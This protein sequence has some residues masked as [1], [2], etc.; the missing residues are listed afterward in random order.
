MLSAT[1]AIKV[2][3]DNLPNGV[4]NSYISYK[5]L[6]VFQVF[7]DDVEEEEYD[8]FFSV[9]KSDGFFSDFSP[10]ADGNLSEI[11]DMFLNHRKDL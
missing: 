9:R 10:V 7:T 4:I 2:V 1:E 11:T 6:Y 3:K 8:P 5:D